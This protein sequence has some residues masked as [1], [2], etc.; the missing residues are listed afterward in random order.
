[1]FKKTILCVFMAAACLVGLCGSAVALE[2]DCDSVYCFQVEDFSSEENLK[3]ICITALPD[4]DTG[5]IVF[6]PQE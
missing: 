1:M 3:G 6:R 2:V 5:T 4:A